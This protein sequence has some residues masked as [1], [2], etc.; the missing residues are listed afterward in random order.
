[1]FT[2]FNTSTNLLLAIPSLGH[3]YFY[4]HTLQQESSF[5]LQTSDVLTI[6]YLY[7]IQT[8]H[9]SMFKCQIHFFKPHKPLTYPS[10]YFY[11]L[12]EEVTISL[13]KPLFF[14]LSSAGGLHAHTVLISFNTSKKLITAIHFISSSKE[15]L[16]TLTVT[17]A[18]RF[19]QSIANLPS[20]YLSS[21]PLPRAF[22]SYNI[23][24][25]PK[26]CT[27]TTI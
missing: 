24:K 14:L 9:P 16:Y 17:Q 4:I 23:L 26:L 6:S 13:N 27:L 2:R 18:L 8:T 11:L 19:L 10:T 15:P 3:Y 7:R 22:T 21:F 12:E 20:I 25:R 5:G 1:M